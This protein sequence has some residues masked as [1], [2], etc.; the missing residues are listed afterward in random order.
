VACQVS[1]LTRLGERAQ[2][3]DAPVDK[4][5]DWQENT[6][7]IFCEDHSLVRDSKWKSGSISNRNHGREANTRGEESEKNYTRAPP[8]RVGR[9]FALLTKTYHGS[10]VPDIEATCPVTAVVSMGRRNTQ[11]EPTWQ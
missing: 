7:S 4:F 5:R 1:P 2:A 3:L 10:R 11:L 9:A 6:N 8:Q